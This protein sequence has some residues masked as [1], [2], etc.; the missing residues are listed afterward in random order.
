MHPRALME[1]HNEIIAI[2]MTANTSPILQPMDQGVVSISSLTEEIH[3]VRLLL[4]NCSVVS[5]SL[6]IYGLQH[7]RPICPSPPPGVCSNSR[8]SNQQCHPTIISSVIPFS[9]LQYFLVSGSFPMSRLFASDS[10]SFGASVSV[11]AMS[12]LI[13]A[14]AVML[15]D[16]SDGSGQSQLKI[17]SK[18]STIL[19]VIKEYLC[20]MSS[21]CQMPVWKK[22]IPALMDDF[23]G[24]MTS[25]GRCG[26]NGKRFRIR[27]EV[28]GYVWITAVS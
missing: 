3:F 15:C 22:L 4:F 6:P 2:F 28:W 13:K 24:F 17:L 12:I 9:W 8:L 16:S 7:A 10:Q 27:S 1:M 21:K 11:P 20:L 23:E 19:D 26:I 5:D 18:R 25:A 14:I